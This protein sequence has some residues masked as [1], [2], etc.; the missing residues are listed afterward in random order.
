MRYVA[1]RLDD[2]HSVKYLRGTIAPPQGQKTPGP[3]GVRAPDTT[4]P[5][6]VRI[7]K[8]PWL[9]P[10]GWSEPLAEGSLSCSPTMA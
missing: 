6:C 3:R 5:P 10:V 9:S 8:R 4:A 7:R 1:E 2:G